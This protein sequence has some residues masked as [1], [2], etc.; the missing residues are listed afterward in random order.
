MWKLTNIQY[1]FL[2][3]WITCFILISSLLTLVFCYKTSVFLFYHILFLPVYFI[4]T[5]ILIKI[6]LVGRIKFSLSWYYQMVGMI[7]I[8]LVISFF[9][10]D[11]RS[12]FGIGFIPNYSLSFERIISSGCREMFNFLSLFFSTIIMVSYDYINNELTS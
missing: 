9:L 8:V 7:T 4:I 5:W 1:L 11:F 3:K 2:F 10:R 12:S 6:Y